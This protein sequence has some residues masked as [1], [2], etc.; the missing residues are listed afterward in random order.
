[1]QSDHGGHESPISRPDSAGSPSDPDG[2]VRRE[3][4][5]AGHSGDAEAARSHLHH[6][7]PEVRAAA[8]GALARIGRLDHDDLAAGLQDPAPG[9]RR[10]AARIAAGQRRLTGALLERLTDDDPT[11]A[12]EAAFALGE[13]DPT[14]E[15]ADAV[16]AA[17]ADMA[18]R[19][20][21]ALCRE[22]S[23]AAL[24]SLGNPAG[25]GAVLAASHDRATVRRR[26]VLA[27]AA[28]E[29]PEVTQTLRKLRDDRD[30]QVRQTAEDLLAI[31][32]GEST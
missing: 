7:D 6:V 24:G 26:A 19:H 20:D 15:L 12:E 32:Q 10:R 1:M 5:V 28:F 25:L 21:D 3:V 14:D 18:G 23:V 8:L 4:V 29:G 31:E 2:R 9:V 13:G 22:S 27:L 16:I 11:V 30:L 17:L